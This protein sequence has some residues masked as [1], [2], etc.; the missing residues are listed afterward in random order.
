MS[1]IVNSHLIIVNVSV[2][3]H[4]THIKAC[5]SASII[6]HHAPSSIIH[7][8]ASIIQHPSNAYQSNSITVNIHHK[9]FVISL[10][11]PVTTPPQTCCIPSAPIRFRFAR[12]Q[13]FNWTSTRRPFPDPHTPSIIQHHAQKRKFAR[14][15]RKLKTI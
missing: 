7:H 6:H 14:F 10:Y 11:A 12:N 3:I 15:T 13:T 4:Q 2:S 1:I 8:P 9:R 5:Q